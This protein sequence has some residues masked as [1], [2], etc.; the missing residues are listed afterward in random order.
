MMC[1]CACP[2]M[3]THFLSHIKHYADISYYSQ[4]PVP[5]ILLPQSV[6]NRLFIVYLGEG[7]ASLR[8]A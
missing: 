4:M 3:Y 8:R 5:Q 2:S 7:E 1:V 6:D